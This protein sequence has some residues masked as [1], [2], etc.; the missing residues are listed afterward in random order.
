MKTK[1]LF[2]SLLIAFSSCSQKQELTLEEKDQIKTELS[3][4]F[5]NFVKI[6]KSL[7][8]NAVLNYYWDSPDFVIVGAD[9]SVK[10]YQGL[11]KDNEELFKSLSSV[12]I[13]TAKQEYM[14]VSKE[15]V[16]IFWLGRFEA[17]MKDES[18]LVFDPDAVTFVFQKINNEWKIT[19]QADSALPPV[20][21]QS[22]TLNKN[23]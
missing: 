22:K 13:I 21:Q 18:L 2:I 1:L 19:Y 14:I 12:K 10:D 7:D 6:Y 5:D 8:P 15:A 3:T 11:K 4:V 23:K 20:I 17:Q 9:G 16:V